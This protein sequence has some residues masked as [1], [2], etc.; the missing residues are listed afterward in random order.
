[1]DTTNHE[2]EHFPCSCHRPEYAYTDSLCPACEEER[3]RESRIDIVQTAPN[4]TYELL[5]NDGKM[6]RID[7]PAAVPDPTRIEEFREPVVKLDI[8]SFPVMVTRRM[9]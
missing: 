2:H 9:A 8:V 3:E 7:S 4:V 1:M 6:V 5:T